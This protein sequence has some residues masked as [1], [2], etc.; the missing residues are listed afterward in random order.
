MKS[1]FTSPVTRLPGML[2]PGGMTS[3]SPVNRKPSDSLVV[4]CSAGQGLA[5]DD[6][7]ADLLDLL[8]S[9]WA[10]MRQIS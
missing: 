5:L 7:V 1:Y 9:F 6:Q 2:D 10:P 3:E 4:E 8:R